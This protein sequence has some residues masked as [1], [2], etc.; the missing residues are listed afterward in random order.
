MYFVVNGIDKPNALQTRLDNRTAHIDY[1]RNP[2]GVKIIVGGPKIGDDG[3]MIGSTMIVEADTKKAVL[4]YL[5]KDPYT[6]ADVFASVEIAE[7]KIGF[8]DG[9]CLL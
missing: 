7:Y 5:E 2:S 4:D 6:K 1:N 3:T 9:T 8:K